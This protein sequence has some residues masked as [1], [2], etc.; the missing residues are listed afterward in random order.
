M[1]L[2]DTAIRNP[3]SAIRNAKPGAKPAKL[4]DV[5]GLFMIVSPAEVSGGDSCKG[6]QKSPET[7]TANPLIGIGCFFF[8]SS[9]SP[10]WS[11][12]GYVWSQFGHII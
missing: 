2:T 4:F 9:F 1:P 11:V 6:L 3:Q 12:F 10:I 7:I 5:R 8:K